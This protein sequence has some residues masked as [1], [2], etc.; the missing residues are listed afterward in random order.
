MDLTWIYVFGIVLFAGSVALC[1]G[2]ITYKVR[3]D[4]ASWK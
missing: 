1:L 4:K 3:R 2:I